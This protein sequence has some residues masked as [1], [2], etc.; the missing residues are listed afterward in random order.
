MR[1]DINKFTRN[2]LVFLTTAFI[3]L[4][5]SAKAVDIQL[6]SMGEASSSIISLNQE[7]ALGQSWLKAF[8]AQADISSDYI[9]QEYVEEILFEMVRYSDMQDKRLEVVIIDNKSLNAFAV[10]GG[11]I[12]VNTG[13]FLHAETEAQLA[14]VLAHELSHISQRHFARSVEEQK[15]NSTANLVGLI[16]GLVLAATSG[17]DAGLALLTATQAATLES[18]LKYSR[19]NEQEADRIGITVLADAGY[20][21]SAMGA[22]FEQMLES[23]KYLGYQAPEYLRTHPLTENRVNDA[24]SRSQQYPR[25]YYEEPDDYKLVRA[26]IDVAESG[27]PD[28][29][30]AKYKAL[31]EREPTDAH[32]YGLALAYLDTLRFTEAKELAKTLYK[33]TPGNRYFGLLYAKTL[34]LSGE[35]EQAEDIIKGYLNQYPNSYSL[36]M[37]FVGLLNQS[38]KFSQSVEILKRM[39]RSRPNDSAVWYQYSETLG[40]AGEILELHKARAE[41]F[42]LVGAF[43]RAIRQLQFAKTEAKGDQIELAIIDQKISKAARYRSSYQ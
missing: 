4:C 37:A 24:L 17:A 30:V 26:R 21:P 10:P 27:S 19:Q 8:R 33:G 39:T 5:N 13:L 25:K 23:T 11:I 16:A 18:S 3:L 32:R 43:D 42:M 7:Y 36:N 35:A 28:Q 22:M 1:S 12:G 41:Y 2:A 9:I 31:E 14:S 40:L 6:P 20:D 15:I 38:T 34:G 29:R